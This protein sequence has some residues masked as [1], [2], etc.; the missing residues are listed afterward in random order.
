MEISTSIVMGVI[1][2]V[3]IAGILGLCILNLA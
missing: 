3:I 2:A 1:Y